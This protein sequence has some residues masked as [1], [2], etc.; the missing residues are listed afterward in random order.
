MWVAGNPITLAITTASQG[1]QE[2]GVKSQGQVSNPGSLMWYMGISTARL[3]ACPFQVGKV[4]LHSHVPQI[5]W[6]WH[7]FPKLLADYNSKV[8]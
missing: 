4:E 8:I 2:A 7:F 3:N 5:A 6:K 1:L